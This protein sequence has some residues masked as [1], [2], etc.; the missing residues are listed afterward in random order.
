[1]DS[2]I[3]EQAAT[4]QLVDELLAH[5]W[6]FQR[7]AGDS[8]APGRD[9][10]N[11]GASLAPSA[12]AFLTRLRATYS[13]DD[14]HVLRALLWPCAAPPGPDDRWWETPLGLVLKSART[15]RTTTTPPYPRRRLQGSA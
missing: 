11:D 15:S 7:I 10:S 8:T 9:L 6:A 2:R 13:D 4:E 3:D 12:H 14:Q 1:M 5:T